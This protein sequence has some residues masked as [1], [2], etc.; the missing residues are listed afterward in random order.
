MVCQPRQSP[1]WQAYRIDV[2]DFMT[3]VG[4]QRPEEFK[5]VTRTHFL[6]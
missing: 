6:A 1:H 2:A 5:I 3:F 4:I